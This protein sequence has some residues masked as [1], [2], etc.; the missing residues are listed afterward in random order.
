MAEPQKAPEA[1]FAEEIK[2]MEY[3]PMLPVEIRLVKWS[4]GLGIA[5]IALLVW[6][7]QTFFEV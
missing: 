4:I 2:N 5:L 3:E 7:S 1:K 6:V